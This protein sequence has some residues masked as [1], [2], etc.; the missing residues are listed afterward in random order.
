MEVTIKFSAL[1]IIPMTASAAALADAAKGDIIVADDE[2]NEDAAEDGEVAA[3]PSPPL[4]LHV[5]AAPPP[6]EH[7]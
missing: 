7:E 5:A 1:L 6:P 2:C 4:P 3:S